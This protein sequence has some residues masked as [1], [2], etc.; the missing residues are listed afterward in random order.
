LARKTILIAIAGASGSGKT[1]LAKWLKGELRDWFKVA[2]LNED[3]YYR[4]QSDLTDKERETTNYD[5]PDAIEE[6]MLVNH[7]VTLKNGDSVDVPVYSYETHD[8]TEETVAVGP[9]EVVIVEGI[10]LLHRTAVREVVDLTVFVDVPEEV[11][12]RR[13]IKRDVSQ[14]GRTRESVLAQYEKTVRPMFHEYVEPSK[15]HADLVL[16]NVEE[17]KA[18]EKLLGELRKLLL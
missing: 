14:R 15:Q 1:S 10:L 5:H 13:R 2:V 11:C 9:C 17:G 6:S 8:R 12:L 7:L 18:H 4:K 16:E 3:S